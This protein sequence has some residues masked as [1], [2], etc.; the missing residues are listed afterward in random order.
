MDIAERL[1]NKY[2][3]WEEGHTRVFTDYLIRY[4]G[5]PE[6]VETLERFLDAHRTPSCIRMI[7]ILP[8]TFQPQWDAEPLYA[9]ALRNEPQHDRQISETSRFADHGS[10]LFV[11]LC[12]SGLSITECENAYQKIA[13]S[14]DF[15]RIMNTL[16]DGYLEERK[17]KA[18]L[19]A[20]IRFRSKNFRKILQAVSA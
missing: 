12:I 3:Y 13:R 7:R 19:A 6:S 2:Q 15:Y 14:R 20:V 16:M 4:A 5:D 17:D 18:T 10:R 9:R 8:E 11:E 1:S